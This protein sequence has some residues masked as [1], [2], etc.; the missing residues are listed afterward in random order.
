MV[1]QRL[2]RIYDLYVLNMEKEYKCLLKIYKCLFY[3][4][5]LTIDVVLWY[6]VILFL[7]CMGRILFRSGLDKQ[8]YIDQG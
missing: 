7:V 5:I 8:N 2:N 4:V 6:S 1:Y 3:N